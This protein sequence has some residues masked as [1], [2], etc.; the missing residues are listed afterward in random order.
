MVRYNVTEMAFDSTCLEI[1]LSA[2]LINLTSLLLFA[3]FYV[4]GI[5]FLTL[6]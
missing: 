3:I 5:V 6:N 1:S 4:P 2:A